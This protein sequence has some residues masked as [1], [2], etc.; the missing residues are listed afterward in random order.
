MAE[1]DQAAAP[2]PLRV[3]TVRGE[4]YHVGGRV[5]IPVARFVTY[6]RAS[7]TI[8]SDRV[9]GWGGGFVRVVPVAVVEE[10]AE[11]ERS[12]AVT[13][14]TSA[15]LRRLLGAAVAVGLFFTAVR[16]LARRLRR[17]NAEG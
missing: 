15:A 13:D 2:G 5:L 7:A 8:G 16:W 14:A 1:Q 11:G 3:E 17:A 10:T 4:P 6:G 12:I 9:G